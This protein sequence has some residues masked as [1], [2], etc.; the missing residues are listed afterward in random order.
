MEVNKGV[1]KISIKVIN[2]INVIVSVFVKIM[3]YR[4]IKILLVLFNWLRKNGVYN[5]KYSVELKFLR[6][7]YVIWIL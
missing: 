5:R 2:L 7:K 1:G 4:I 6:V 3:V